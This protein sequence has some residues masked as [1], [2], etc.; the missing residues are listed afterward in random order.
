MPKIKL[1]HCVKTSSI[2]LTLCPVEEIVTVHWSPE[3]A[4][5][6]SH[7]ILWS[8]TK[9]NMFA[10]DRLVPHVSCW[11]MKVPL[12]G[13]DRGRAALFNSHT[14]VLQ[15]SKDVV[16]SGLFGGAEQDFSFRFPGIL[17]FNN[18]TICFDDMRWLELFRPG[19][20]NKPLPP[21]QENT[22]VQQTG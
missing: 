14:D 7:C 22:S 21:P 10:T 13:A 20:Q 18:F 9:W 17:S 2:A 8:R 4:S 12:P 5:R 16:R 11:G 1:S 19:V 15:N 6:K 3:R